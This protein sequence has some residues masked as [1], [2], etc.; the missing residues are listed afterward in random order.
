VRLRV[1]GFGSADENP[2]SRALVRELTRLGA[3]VV[4]VRLP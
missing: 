3:G 1:A 4:A 2:V